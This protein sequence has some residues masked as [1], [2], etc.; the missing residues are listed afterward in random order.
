MPRPEAVLCRMPS[1]ALLDAI[2]PNMQKDI[3]AHVLRS[4]GKLQKA[5]GYLLM[6][7]MWMVTAEGGTPDEA[8]RARAAMPDSLEFAPGR[9]EGLMLTIE[10]GATGYR[11]W[12]AEILREPTRL[13]E[14]EERELSGAEGRL[15]DLK[16]WRS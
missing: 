4:Q 8:Y 6:T 12:F 1:N 3:F 16:D 13:L 11:M 9:K 14:W 15:V 7:E 2:H 5:L 10:H